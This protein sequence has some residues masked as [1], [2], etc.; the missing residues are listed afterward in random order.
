MVFEEILSRPNGANPCWADLAVKT[1]ASPD[2]RTPQ[3]FDPS[4]AKSREEIIDKIVAAALDRDVRLL[5]TAD[6]NL[7]FDEQGVW[8]DEL[9]KK[10]K[11]RGVS[12]YPGVR[13]LLEDGLD[14]LALF[15]PGL[16]Q[17]EISNFLTDLGLPGNARFYRNNKPVLITLS[18]RE[19]V[20]RVRAANGMVLIIHN[21]A[22]KDHP[23]VVKDPWVWGVILPAG[24]QNL[25]S[26]DEAMLSG[27]LKGFERRLP[28]ARLAGSLASKPEDTGSK[29]VSIELGTHNLEGL[30]I[31][32]LDSKVKV[33]FP[34]EIE[35]R[36]YSRLMAVRWEGGFLDG[37]SINFNSSF[38]AMIGGRGTGKTTII[39]TMRYALDEPPKTDRNRENHDQ[40]L[41]DVFLPGSKISLMVESHEPTPKRYVI[42]RIFPFD[43]VVRDAETGEKL[44]LNPTDIFRAEVF[45]NKEIYEISKQ[46]DFQLRLLERL[47]EKDLVSLQAQEDLLLEKLEEQ[48]Q[49]IVRLSEDLDRRDTE[50]GKL[51]AAEEKLSRFLEMDIPAKI[52][53]KRKLEQEG[54]IFERGEGVLAD[55][56]K[57]L[58]ELISESSSRLKSLQEEEKAPLNPELLDEYT[59]TLVEFV[60]DFES[61]VQGLVESLQGTE[62]KH[63]TFHEQWHR[64][65]TEGEERFQESLRSLQERFPGVDVNEYISIEKE[66]M[67]LRERKTERDAVASKLSMRRDER[68]ALLGQVKEL[69]A[70]RFEVLKKRADGW[71][72]ELGGKIH[73]ELLV[74]GT[75]NRLA[76]ELRHFM[77]QLSKEEALRIVSDEQFG[78]DELVKRARAGDREGLTELLKIPPEKLVPS[79]DEETLSRMEIVSIPPEVVIKLNLGTE[80]DPSYRDVGHLSDGQRCTAILGILLLES[81]YPL[82]VDQPEEDLDNAFIVEEIA[83][84]FRDQMGK[85]Q[86]LVATH[87]ANIPVLGD[88]A[89]IVALEADV[90]HAYLREGRYGYIDSP[91]IKELVEQI[92][93]GGREAFEIRK[94]KYGL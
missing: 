26:E 20:A 81:P 16:P 55:I 65:Y 54:H 64:L 5:G 18:P 45:G 85:R 25:T 36:S 13:L 23:A 42:E 24:P 75:P 19:V 14:V 2:Y 38:N 22:L 49:E 34:H 7:G 51:S 79:F 46:Q 68:R 73:I 31:A 80:K 60:G 9:G 62:E 89:Q 82:L 78:F 63:R 67:R 17:E 48:N 74:K 70:S 43:P 77:P 28:L 37:L 57:K 87:N 52:D 12:V 76:A 53:E 94:E 40:I 83:E 29:R 56:K 41:R 61:K 3:D 21:D 84:R 50:L 32:L 6:Y 71:N 72:T 93:E 58:L 86:F 59:N 88:A 33:K 47:C 30:R 66:V 15:E 69:R 91:K 11:E 39:E 35:K 92:L 90:D 10:A 27:K 44:E 8:L 1:P 4:S